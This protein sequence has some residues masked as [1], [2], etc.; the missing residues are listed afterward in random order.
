MKNEE[1]FCN[2]A[3]IQNGKE[4][5]ILKH[6]VMW[7]FKDE[8]EGRTRAENA[9][10]MKEHLEALVGKIPEL[11]SAEVGINIKESEA[12]YDAVLTA[13]FRNIEDL[14]TYKKH[15]LHQEVSNY[16]KGVRLSRVVCDYF[17]DE[18]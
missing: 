11:L 8:A 7:K 2:F 1:Y 17:V 12:A 6:I 18:K 16:C 3:E 10:W 13:T 14:E 5:K 9:E 4:M 15:P